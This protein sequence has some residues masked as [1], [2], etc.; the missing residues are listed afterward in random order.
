MTQGITAGFRALLGRLRTYQVDWN[1]VRDG[2]Y[3]PGTDRVEKPL[4]YANV[5]SSELKPESDDFFQPVDARRHVIALDIDYPAYL[6]PST[7][8]DHSHLYLDVPGGVKH[9]DYMEL[10]DLLGRMGVIEPG[11]AAVSRLRGHTDLRLPWVP[12]DPSDRPDPLE[13]F[14]VDQLMVL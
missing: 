3:D 7:T 6:I 1:P 11:Y 10:L 14:A 4:T 9:E 12:K 8:A 5:V 13:T 2:N